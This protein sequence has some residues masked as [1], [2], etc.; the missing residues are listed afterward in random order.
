MVR[1][2]TGEAGE[3][4]QTTQR[5]VHL[6]RRAA[7]LVALDFLDEVVRQLLAFDQ[8]QERAARVE[9][10][11]DDRRGD[12]VAV[13]E[14]DAAH[15]AVLHEHALDRRVRANLGAERARRRRD[16]L[17]DRARSALLK[18]PRSKR[19]VDL[20]HVVMQQH[21]RRAGRPRAEKRADDAARRL[22]RFE[23]IELV[24][25]VEIVGAAHRHQLVERVK[26]LRAQ[27][28][29]VTA[30]LEQSAQIRRRE[31]RRIGRHHAE[32]RL[33]GHRHVVHQAPELDGRFGVTRRMPRQ[34]APRLVGVGPPR[35]IVAVVERRDRAL[36]R[37]DLQPVAR[38]VEI[39]NDL[40]PQQ[41]HHI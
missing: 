31:R 14:D 16:G 29:Q 9:P 19:A 37:Q 20:A 39:A 28:P 6:A 8:L 4:R 30:E 40:R 23:R 21:V 32:D 41:T 38:Q 13:L 33:H 1:S 27:R 7:K 11:D 34:L 24:P 22:R 36:E 26:S 17:A 2:D 35:E 12:L 18:P 5:Q 15:A 25:L 10:G 3:L